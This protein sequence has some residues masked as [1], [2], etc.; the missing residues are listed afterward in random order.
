MSWPLSKIKIQ[1]ETMDYFK[2]ANAYVWDLDWQFWKIKYIWDKISEPLNIVFVRE[3]CTY[4]ENCFYFQGAVQKCRL[5]ML[6]TAFCVGMFK[7]IINCRKYRTI[8]E[9]FELDILKIVALNRLL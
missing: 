8:Y 4:N 3:L 9:C 1:L 7:L 6:C 2:E 5:Y